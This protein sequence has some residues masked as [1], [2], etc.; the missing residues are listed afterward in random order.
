[1]SATYE[2]GLKG[3][4]SQ[5]AAL[6]QETE[7]YEGDFRKLPEAERDLA[8]LMRLTKVNDNIY[9]FLLQKHEEARITKAA[10]IS[11]T[12][13]VDA[14]TTPKLRSSPTGAKT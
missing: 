9:T 3:L 6:K 10:T 4:T 14:A 1:M 5:Q 7:R 11:S 8:R 13:V 12:T 2:A